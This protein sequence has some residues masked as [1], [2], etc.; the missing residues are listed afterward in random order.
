MTF[1]A[2]SLT[3]ALLGSLFAVQSQGE[4]IILAG[5][6]PAADETVRTI[7]VTGTRIQTPN[8]TSASPV[9]SIRNEDFVLTGVPNVEQT[10]N[11][12]PQLVP[13]FTSTSNNP[14]TGAATLDLRGM[15]SVRTLILVNGRRWIANDAGQ[16]PEIDVNTIPAALVERVDIVTGGASA[17]YGSDAVTGVINFILKSRLEGLH[18]EARS[19]ITEK[20]DGASRSADLTF[21]TPFLGG[22]GNLLVSGGWL[23][24]DPVFQADR[25]F[26][27]STFGDGCI[28]AGSNDRFGVGQATGSFSCTGANEEWGLVRLGS[29]TIP[30]GRIFGFP[31]AFLFPTGIGGGLQRISQVR[32]APG[33]DLVPYNFATD[34]YNYAPSNYLQVPLDRLS[35]NILASLEISPAFE[36]YTELSIV[37]TISR[38]QLA[39]APAMIGTGADS[40]F[41]A[42]INLDNPFLTEEARRILEIT[43][44]VDSA[45]RRGFVGS[46]ATGFTI[47]PAFTGDADGLVGPVRLS[48]RLS[49]LGPRQAENERMARRGLIGLRGELSEAWSYDGYYSHSYVE[50]DTRFA[51]SASAR[52]LQQAILVRADSSGAVSCTD[53]SNGCVPINIFGQQDISAE[54]AE[55]LRIHPLERTEVK[56]Q[57]AEAVVK[58][59]LASLPAGPLK[60]VLGTSWRRTSYTFVPD[61]SFEEGDTLGFLKSIG[62]AGST[63]VFELFGEALVPIAEG[64][65]FAHEMNAELGLRYSDYDSVGGVW[66][67]KALGNWSPLPEVRFRAGLQKAVRAPNARELYEESLTDFGFVLDPCAPIDG[68]TQT[69]EVIAACA[70]NGAADLPE[71]FYFTLVTTG[72][73]ENL[74]AETA[75]TLTIGAVVQPLPR[76]SATV[77]YYDIR[78]RDAIGVFGGGSSYVVA[79]CIYGG[80]DPSDPLCQAFDRGPDGFVS[81]VRTPTANL[82][83]LR[84]R[85]I[86]FQL[87]YGFRF[88]RGN[89]QAN[90][91]GTRLL[92]TEVQF[93]AGVEPLQCAGFFGFPCGNTIQGVATPRWKFFNRFN[94]NRGAVALSLRHRYF[95]ATKDARIAG[96]AVFGEPPPTNIPVVAATMGSRHYFDLSTSF[97]V[98]ERFNL[99][100]GA[101]NLT[102]AKPSLVG[103]QQVQANTD[104]SLYDVLG[105]RFFVTLAA[106]L[107]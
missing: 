35:G 10:L 61:D 77:D 15:G 9:E 38:Q 22:L 43:L 62:A 26:S 86:D 8:R 59:D 54:A 48:S 45:G 47:N 67:W 103:S 17:V 91:S 84:T 18:L 40:V 82:S 20:G 64:R 33:G 105:R 41:P 95:S 69:P 56:E 49:G 79:G 23:D 101:N 39:P 93:N 42:Q 87:G 4:P 27:Q 66:T 51:N 74:E 1:G 53:P 94:W 12:L 88:L 81:A 19:N 55:F 31:P 21:G 2:G 100:L 32:F 34:S 57:I 29:P 65:R 46:P 13:S 50:H 60:A 99:T 7:Y 58:G 85:G 68:F 36:P 96:R 30:Q 76:L 78:I 11:Q 89:F 90:L 24:Q 52:R 92:K 75:R 98:S 97:R 14:G 72:G 73:S 16:I 37:R 102:D 44:G 83:R 80:G 70:R 6:P 5:D 63:S 106:R 107:F 3:S 71:D 28:I 25:L 104:P